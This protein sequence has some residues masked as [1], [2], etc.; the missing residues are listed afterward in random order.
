MCRAYE[1]SHRRKFTVETTVLLFPFG[2][3]CADESPRKDAKKWCSIFMAFMGESVYE[4]ASH[5]DDRRYPRFPLPE[6]QG[7]GRRARTVDPR[8]DPF[9]RAGHSHRGQASAFQE[10]QVSPHRV[11][12]AESRFDQRTDL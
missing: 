7:A 12:W 1:E 4:R 5:S 3:S 11:R 2:F 10:G 8:I 9:G 6:A